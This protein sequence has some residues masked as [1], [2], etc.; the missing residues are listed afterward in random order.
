MKNNLKLV[1]AVAVATTF[2][3][4]AHKATRALVDSSGMAVKGGFGQCIVTQWNKEHSDC[5][6]AKAPEMVEVG[7]RL[8]AHTL[9]DFDKSTLR[10]EGKAELNALAT[11]IKHGKE[12]GKIKD[13]MGVR[14]VGHTDSRGSQAY[15][16]GLSERR[17]ASVRNYLVQQ[18]VSP[19]KIA[20]SGEGKL[21]PVASNATAEGRQQNRRV[22]ITVQGV[23]VESN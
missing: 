10:P 14:V 7:F 8:G 21:N 19:S 17:A 2:A 16:Q 18:G 9:F 6:A 12:L 22:D 1:L 23:E 15:N 3:A 13:V 11:K 20:A 4:S 5:G